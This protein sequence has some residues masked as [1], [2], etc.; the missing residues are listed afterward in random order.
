MTVEAE[1]EEPKH[2]VTASDQHQSIQH[3]R[4]KQIIYI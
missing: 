1:R 3:I 4:R 2:K